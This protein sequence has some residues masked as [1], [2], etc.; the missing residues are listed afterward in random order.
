MAFTYCT[1]F[2]K[3]N[4]AVIIL[5]REAPVHL[6]VRKENRAYINQNQKL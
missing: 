4:C 2:W 1:I 5:Q 3:K 6:D